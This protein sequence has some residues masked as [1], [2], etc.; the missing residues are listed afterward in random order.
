MR[1]PCCLCVSVPATNS[2]EPGIS[3]YN[4]ILLLSYNTVTWTAKAFLDND[5]VNAL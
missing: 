1:S 5:S 3:E 2:S 4:N